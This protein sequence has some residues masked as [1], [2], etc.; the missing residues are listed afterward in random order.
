VIASWRS[1]PTKVP[2]SR[3][4]GSPE[5]A[6]LTVALVGGALRAPA[7]DLHLTR[8]TLQTHGIEACVEMVPATL[9][10]VF[11]TVGAGV[12]EPAHR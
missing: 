1:A 8:E 2:Y 5:T 9:E 7:A 10:E 11:G 3:P 4:V 12:N 6:G